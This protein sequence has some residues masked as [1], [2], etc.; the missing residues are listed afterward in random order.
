MNFLERARSVRKDPTA[1]TSAGVT[2]TLWSIEEFLHVVG[3]T[4]AGIR[5]DLINER[6]DVAFIRVQTLHCRVTDELT[7]VHNSKGVE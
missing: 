4:L 5:A 6:Y 1:E 3:G 2:E 7:T